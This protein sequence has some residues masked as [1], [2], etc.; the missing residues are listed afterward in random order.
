MLAVPLISLGE[1]HFAFALEKDQLE[2]SSITPPNA[3]IENLFIEPAVLRSIFEHG[4]MGIAGTFRRA[5]T[6]W[7][8]RPQ[9]I[10][11]ANH[12]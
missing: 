7:A 3:G 12:L 6:K 11:A 2:R 9:K 10:A 1:R 8:P 5:G 4:C